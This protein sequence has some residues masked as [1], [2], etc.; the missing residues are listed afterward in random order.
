MLTCSVTD[1]VIVVDAMR[2]QLDALMGIDRNGEPSVKRNFTDRDVCT[3][4]LAGLCAHELFNN[5]VCNYSSSSS[6][7]TPI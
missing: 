2:R 1:S 3:S 6:F 5:T 7:N 4:Y